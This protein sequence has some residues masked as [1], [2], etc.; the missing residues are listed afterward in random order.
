MDAAAI[1]AVGVDHQVITLLFSPLLDVH[2]TLGIERGN[3]A[4]HYNLS[5]DGTSIDITL[6]EGLSW[7][8]GMPLTVDDVVYSYTALYLNPAVPSIGDCSP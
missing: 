5:P 7:S 6:R 1:P 8:D 4:E 3:L 2:P